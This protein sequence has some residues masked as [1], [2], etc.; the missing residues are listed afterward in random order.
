MP[1]TKL[2]YK[3]ELFKDMG[4]TSAEDMSKIE[5]EEYF[6]IENKY[7][8][9]SLEEVKKAIA[10]EKIRLK[11]DKEKKLQS[12][13]ESYQAGLQQAQNDYD[14]SMTYERTKF[15]GSADEADLE[16]CY[17]KQNEYM[18][19]MDG[20]ED[21]WSKSL[22]KDLSGNKMIYPTLDDL[23]N[24]INEEIEYKDFPSGS[25]RRTS[26]YESLTKEE[27]ELFG[28]YYYANESFLRN[29][30][31]IKELEE[32]LH[33]EQKKEEKNQEEVKEE[34]IEVE[35]L[36]INKEL[37]LSKG[38]TIDEKRSVLGGKNITLEEKNKYTEEEI[39][40]INAQANKNKQHALKEKEILDNKN[41][42]TLTQMANRD[43]SIKKINSE[44]ENKIENLKKDEAYC[45]K[46]ESI[47]LTRLTA[48]QE[49]MEGAWSK[50]VE[51]QK[52]FDKLNGWQKFWASVL[53]S[54]LYKKAELYDRVEGYKESMKEMGF[55]QSEIDKELKN[56]IEAK[57]EGKVVP[58]E[59]K[60]VDQKDF[61]K[62][63]GK[64]T[65]SPELSNNNL[66]QSKQVNV[67]NKKEKINTKDK[68]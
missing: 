8:G 5:S 4:K 64:E 9:K 28:D 1:K 19:E 11:E 62:N 54:K 46:R 29:E 39:K 24:K 16:N 47:E 3:N 6:E 61:N 35:M 67:E 13:E 44:Y 50:Y 2:E 56:R 43:A 21:S 15:L 26:I 14:E 63:L 7:P 12:A 10:A 53:S 57:E 31:E 17:R 48:K 18:K 36:D 38:L 41:R 34:D 52:N 20:Y 55:T 37:S 60:K 45:A 22:D 33:P 27:Q 25:F 65:E 42:E 23:L 49:R 32:K 40:Q 68:K 51:A 58:K 30:K 59:N 66:S